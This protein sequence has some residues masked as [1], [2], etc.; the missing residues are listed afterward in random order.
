MAVVWSD[1]TIVLIREVMSDVIGK[2]GSKQN[3]EDRAI[4]RGI[5]TWSSELEILLLW[6]AERQA[7]SF[8]L[9]LEVKL[10]SALHLCPSSPHPS[11]FLTSFFCFK[12]TW[13]WIVP[14][15]V[16]PGSSSSCAWK[17]S[18]KDTG[19]PVSSLIQQFTCYV[20]DLQVPLFLCTHLRRQ[21]RAFTT[22]YCQL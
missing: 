16:P 12:S 5:W 3:T 22:M 15:Q 13:S 17:L 2:E 7:S 4:Q 11:S 1:C 8:S 9:G 18:K 20:S 21:G 14:A 10:C 6:K 19:D